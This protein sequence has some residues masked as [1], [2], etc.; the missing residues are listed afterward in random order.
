MHYLQLLFELL[1]KQF[2]PKKLSLLT[3]ACYH[4]CKT[5]SKDA[6]LWTLHYRKFGY[7]PIPAITVAKENETVTL[8]SLRHTSR[9]LQLMDFTAFRKHDRIILALVTGCC[10]NPRKPVT[11][12][13]V[14][15]ITVK[16]I[17][18]PCTNTTLKTGSM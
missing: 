1:T 6:A 5:L 15:S 8:I 10:Q 3:T 17:S 16:S 14:A 4:M 2:D 13:N 9:K 12:H 18:K 11:I 7:L